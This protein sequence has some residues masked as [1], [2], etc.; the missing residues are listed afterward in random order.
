MSCSAAFIPCYACNAITVFYY[1]I[2]LL[3]SMIP[4]NCRSWGIRFLTDEISSLK[5]S[6]YIGP[7]C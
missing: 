2:F 3:T 7:Q 4:S 5:Y 6:P 1:I